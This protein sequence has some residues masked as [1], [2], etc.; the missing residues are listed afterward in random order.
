MSFLRTF[1]HFPY[2]SRARIWKNSIWVNIFYYYWVFQSFIQG[3]EVKFEMRDQECRCITTEIKQILWRTTGAFDRYDSFFLIMF[4]KSAIFQILPLF[5]KKKN[6]IGDTWRNVFIS[7]STIYVCWNWVWN[8]I[9][10]PRTST[11]IKSCLMRTVKKNELQGK[12]YEIASS[13][14]LK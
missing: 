7:N 4:L 3:R 9:Y 14:S 11:G 10:L 2:F 1:I 8:Q 12:K 5:K 13:E 6:R